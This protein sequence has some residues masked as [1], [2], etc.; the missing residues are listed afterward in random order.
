VSE[1]PRDD[2]AESQNEPAMWQPPLPT[3]MIDPSRAEERP[4]PAD[5]GYRAPP[6]QPSRDEGVDFLPAAVAG[7]LVAVLAGI[8]WGL[9]ARWTD[10]EL[11]IL[12]W[13][14]GV[15]V[16]SA[17]LSVARRRTPSLQVLAVV[18]AL[19]GL[20][21]GKYLAFAFVLQD[22][23]REVGTGIGVLSRD[24]LHEFRTSL[25]EVFGRFDLLW[26]VLG[27][28]SAWAML[29]PDEAE[30]AGRPPVLASSADAAGEALPPWPAQPPHHSRNPV[31]R[32]A[33]RLPQPWRTIV[34]WVVTIA[35]AVAIVL[36]IKAYVVNPYR[37]PSSSMEPTL[38]C[39]R[40]TS[41]CEAR[42][43]DRVLANR[44]I[45]H[46]RD[47]KRG[48]IV[49]FKT[50]PQA[51]I[52]CGAGG[53]FVKRIIG[54]PG[55]RLEVRVLRGKQYVFINGRKLIEPYIQDSR[56][57]ASSAFQPITVPKNSYF[58][59]GD[60]RSQSCDSRAWGSVPR[61]NLIGKVFMT[62]WPPNRVSFH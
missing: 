26:I 58:M 53:T 54:L 47:P 56:R 8:A 57:V 36:L 12:A 55:D 10:R 19:V 50:P 43:S 38:H 45:Y 46:F 40:P 27:A 2:L 21:I 3:S 32:L 48:E 52:R 14:V 7:G 24:M 34:D 51:K 62:Y 35:G 9:A 49:V 11:G 60:N 39:A 42:F 31:D 41:G 16:G 6:P 5:T 25:R 29:V 18:L 13:G 20:L 33:Q 37:I 15:A 22:Q 17:I 23:L 28:G 4:L 1:R 59:M 44:F 30:D 61:G